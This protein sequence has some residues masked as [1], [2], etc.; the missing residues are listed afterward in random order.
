M[1]LKNNDKKIRKQTSLAECDTM[2]LFVIIKAMKCCWPNIQ[3][4]PNIEYTCRCQFGIQAL[5]NLSFNN[6][7]SNDDNFKQSAIKRCF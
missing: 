5:N 3:I 2:I 7:R 6:Y 4:K 1:V